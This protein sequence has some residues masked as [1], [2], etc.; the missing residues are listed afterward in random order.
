MNIKLQ[1]TPIG[2]RR[3]LKTAPLLEPLEWMSDLAHLKELIAQRSQ[4]QV[5]G[6]KSYF[7]VSGSDLCLMLEVVG[8]PRNP[9]QKTLTLMDL[10]A[11]D[12]LVLELQEDLFSIDFASVLA[13]AEKVKLALGTG[14]N[15]LH[16]LFHLVLD[17]EKIALHFFRQKDYSQ[18][19]L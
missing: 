13:R 12:L 15:R 10:E 5:V 6:Q 16:D 14:E 11:L 9:D 8:V 4:F 3:F 18:N 17:G 1:K 19:L 7:E 2:R